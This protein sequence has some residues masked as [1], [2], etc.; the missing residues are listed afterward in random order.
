MTKYNLPVDY[1]KLKQW[2]RREVRLQYIE[3]QKG[4][5]HYCREDLSKP[6]SINKSINKRLF[7]QGFFNHPVHLHH[8]HESG[9][10]IG[11]VHCYCNAYLFQYHGE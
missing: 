10:T 5:C 8:S 9:L 1:T 2:E 4:K 6:T 11:A 3:Q 7:P